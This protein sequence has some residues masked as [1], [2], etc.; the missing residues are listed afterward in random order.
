MADVVHL[1]RSA[2]G[3]AVVAIEDAEHRNTFSAGV[4]TGLTRTFEAIGTDESIRVVVLHGYDSVFCAG[5][6][7]EE[8]LA[9]A[10][11]EMEFA[12]GDFF[13]MLLDCPV[14]VVS[15][16][17]GHALGGGLVF[18]L[19]ADLIVLSE[20]SIYATN[21]MKYGFTPG[22]GATL[23]VREKLGPALANEMLF[24]A[25]AYHGGTL[26]DRGVPVPVV[27]REKVIDT[28]RSLARELADK[29]RL[30]LTLLKQEMTLPIVR[31]LP[32][33]VEAE[34]RMHRLSFENPEVR[35]RIENRFGR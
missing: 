23:I 8:L 10:D 30:S 7:Q 14:P 29:P 11:G 19:Y 24:T 13:R 26:R 3:V 6:T 28:A 20:E 33:T 27:A 32:A 21:F 1:S 16:M 34:T 4:V 17:Q 18:G 25:S 22:M 5:G 35:A 31:A 9:I 12:Q 15:A 2:D